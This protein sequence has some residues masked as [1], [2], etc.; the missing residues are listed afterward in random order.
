MEKSYIIGCDEVGYGSLSG[1]L[2]IGAVRALKDWAIPGLNDSKKLTDKQRRIM[3][4]QIWF[5]GLSGD[6]QIITAERTNKHIDEFG[7]VVSLRD[8]YKEVAES[9]YTQD[10]LV[11]ID[12][13]L[14]FDKILVNMDYQTIIKADGKVPTVM[15]ASILAKVYRDDLMIKLS[16]KFPAYSFEKNKGY[17][18]SKHIDAIK[19]YGYT[20]FHRQSYKLK[21]EK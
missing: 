4:D 12:G 6:I 10:S 13:N 15:A 9:L 21:S 14:N 2:V 17:G 19:K 1:P 8:C 18:S 7:I 16:E 3:S 20:E 11:I 5:C